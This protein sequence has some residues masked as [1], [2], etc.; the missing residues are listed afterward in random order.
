[1][2]EVESAGSGSG[3]ALGIG[4]GARSH[5]ERRELRTGAH[6]RSPDPD[7]AAVPASPALYSPAPARPAAPPS[8]PRP[9]KS[10]LTIPM[11]AQSSLSHWTT[12]RSGMLAFSRGTMSS[13]RPWHIT[14]PP[15]C[16][17]RWRGR[18]W[19]CCHSLPNSLNRRIVEVETDLAQVSLERFLG[20][21]PLEVVHHLRQPIDLLGLRARALCQLRARRC[22]RDT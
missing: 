4:S 10:T 1:M 9:S 13:R 20:I 5:S 7:I 14:M 15:E 8:C 18:S 22:G 21:D 3:F 17:P 16:W 12:T 19:I 6:S 2:G 11:S